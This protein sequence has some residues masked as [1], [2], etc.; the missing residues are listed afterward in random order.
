M[1]EPLVS[2]IVIFLDEE[3]FLRQAI[4]SVLS[5]THDRWEL[6]LVDD[7]SRDA[8]AQIAHSFVE[9]RPD[10]IRYLQHLGGENRG[11]SASRN[12]G[13]RN[14][15]GGYLAFLD[16]DDIWMPEKLARQLAILESQ[17]AAAMVY[18]KTEYWYDDEAET[19][20]P[21]RSWI[22]EHGITGEVMLEPP[23]A[24][25]HFISGEAAVPCSCSILVRRQAI[26]V[27]GGFEDSFRGLYEDQAFYA[28]ICL[29]QPVYV[30]D[31]CLER[32]RQHPASA[33][34]TMADTD[35]SAAA[36]RRYLDWLVGYVRLRGVD[37]A[38]LWQAL[39]KERWLA[40][41][42]VD[43][44][45]V[46]AQTRWLRKWRARLEDSLLSAAARRRLWAGRATRL[47][48]AFTDKTTSSDEDA[49]A[50]GE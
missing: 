23:Q 9:Q 36:R 24:V 27:V 31:L 39:V 13:I 42:P 32:Y 40:G 17:P 26:E 38:D 3:R 47:G 34:A 44:P 5:Q 37:D 11:M 2:V 33:T 10:R 29:E 35:S 22:Q 45:R 16:G 14:A 25:S 21:K 7:G 18:G 48:G 46:A 30:S 1:P 6:L 8:S 4:E 12:L 50:R 49:S 15:T 20:G 41:K 43:S 19:R 28:K